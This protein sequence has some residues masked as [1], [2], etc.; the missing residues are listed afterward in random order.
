M[1]MVNYLAFITFIFSFY[2]FSQTTH[3]NFKG[4]TGNNATVAIPASISPDIFGDTLVAGDEIGVFTPSGLCVGGAVWTGDNIALTIWG[5]DEQTAEIDGIREGERI[6]YRIWR[7]SEDREYPV[8]LVKYSQGDGIYRIDGIY[9][10][11]ALSTRYP[12]GIEILSPVDGDTVR[13]DSVVVIWKADETVVER[14]RIEVSSDPSFTTYL[15]VDTGV[16]DTFY[17]LRGLINDMKYHLRVKAYNKLGWG[18]YGNLVD[19]EVHIGIPR[20]RLTDEVIRFPETAIGDTSFLTAWIK[21]YSYFGTVFGAYIPP[22][23]FGSD[24]SNGTIGARD[25]VGIAIY[26]SPGSFGDFT[27]KMFFYF[28]DTLV[29][30][31]EGSSPLPEI[32]VDFQEINFGKVNKGTTDSREILIRNR[33]VNRLRIDSIKTLTRYFGV[34]GLN[35]PVYVTDS[36]NLT[37]EFSPDSVVEY[38]DTLYIYNN[39]PVSPFKIALRGVGDIGVNIVDAVRVPERFSLYQ[40]YPNPFNSFTIIEFDLPVE[41]YVKLSVYDLLGHE[42]ARLIDGR[43]RAGRYRLMFDGGS[44]PSGIYLY[45]LDAESFRYM[46]KMILIK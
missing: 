24:F 4:N 19:F 36:L 25:S 16:V 21:N 27:S 20:L 6:Y 14:Y 15:L 11:S 22:G 18:D 2:L 13:S 42:V 35:F 1:K 32:V 40:N 28:G 29:L 30:T 9:V 33:S 7:K 43:L 44:L 17:V 31:L 45:K 46:R 23:D 5:D 26:F 34:T 12:S 10:I 37:V 39:S 38:I 41:S 8:T 3:F